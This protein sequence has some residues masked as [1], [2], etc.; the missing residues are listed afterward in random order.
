M[1]VGLVSARS[2]RL[3]A[4][5]MISAPAAVG[6]SATPGSRRVVRSVTASR[7]RRRRL[8]MPTPATIVAGIVDISIPVVVMPVIIVATAPTSITPAIVTNPRT[9]RQQNRET[10]RQHIKNF[11]IPIEARMAR[12][13]NGVNTP[14][15]QNLNMPGKWHRQNQAPS[16]SVEYFPSAA[17]LLHFARLWS[18]FCAAGTFSATP[19]HALSAGA[20]NA[21]P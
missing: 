1:L 21:R 16:K 4:S 15:G 14:V 11:H 13:S 12:S 5:R 17:R 8:R 6:C 18:A 3:T 7:M 19:F 2:G 10:E 20:C 9:S